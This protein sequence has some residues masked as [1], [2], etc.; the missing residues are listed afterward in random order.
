MR[1]A[2]RASRR[3]GRLAHVG[4]TRARLRAKITFAQNRRTHGMWQQAIPSR[5]IDELPVAHVEV[6]EDRGFHGSYGQSRFDSAGDFVRQ[7]LLRDAG[8]A[9][10]PA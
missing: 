5:F 9:A 2:A 3:S 7:R 1:P 4:L 6:A 8:L 10:R